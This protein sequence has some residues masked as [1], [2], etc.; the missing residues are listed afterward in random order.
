[1]GSAGDLRDYQSVLDFLTSRINYE[2][3]S[4][5]P[6]Q[7]AEFKLD[8][9]RRL[10]ALLG[11]PHLAFPAVHIAGTKGKGS[12][13]AMVAA[14]LRAAGYKTALYTSPHLESVEE[15]IAVDGP[16]S[17]DDFVRL[18]DELQAPVAQVDR[19]FESTGGNGPTY[20]EITTAM[21][22]LHFARQRVDAAVLEVGL[23]GRLD[24]TN[25]CR[26]KVCIITSISFD[27]MRQLGNTLAAIAGEKAGII[28]PQVPVISGVLSDE[29]RRVIHDVA[30]A[31]GAPLYQRR[32]DFDF[33]YLSGNPFDR[34][35][36]REPAES[37][38]L[39]LNDLKIGLL[40]EHQAANAAA[41]IS[42]VLRLAEQG[43]KIDESAIRKGL[44]QAHCPARIEIVRER[45]TVILDVAHNAA[46]MEALLSVLNQRYPTG[47]RILIF[48][49][50]RDKDTP[51]MLRLL[52]PQFDCLL[53]TRYTINPRGLEV[54]QLQEMTQQAL[55]GRAPTELNSQPM[56][57]SRIETTATSA[58]AWRRALEIA[59]PE[60]LICITGSFFLATELQPLVSAATLDPNAQRK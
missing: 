53:L 36:Y 3:T 29:P 46:S 50:S 57:E 24:S 15:R 45:P 8:R 55:S 4:S 11:D 51:S 2:R 21:A 38:K 60:D 13:A 17:Q 6:Y 54:D 25:V 31:N 44:E 19:E 33:D 56:R 14:I 52:V 27:H 58:E 59:Q 34:M 40:G 12:T 9:M 7:E 32:R 37:P 28:K 1:M 16:C 22:F 18:A 42:A 41:A 43:W 26:S 5:V 39:A 48:A 23:G 30:A 47:R 10:L 35:N 49:S 20:F